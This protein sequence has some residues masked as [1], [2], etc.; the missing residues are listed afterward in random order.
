MA[1]AACELTTTAAGPQ[2]PLR[3]V[4]CGGSA[5]TAA[6]RTAQRV[7]Y[8]RR[9]AALGLLAV[10]LLVGAAVVLIGRSAPVAGPAT[11]AATEAEASTIV[12]VVQPGDTLWEVALP[13]V[14]AGVH[15]TAYVSQIAADNGVDPRQLQAGTVLRLPAG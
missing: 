2:Q 11:E 1:A 14:P 7:V 8:R 15:P 5:R 10:A 3:L 6:R 12:V 13:H 9:R 4:P